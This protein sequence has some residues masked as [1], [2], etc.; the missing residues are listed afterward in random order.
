M[1]IPEVHDFDAHSAAREFLKLGF[2]AVDD[3]GASLYECAEAEL[4]DELGVAVDEMD[5]VTD[6]IETDLGPVFVF[7]DEARI[8]LQHVTQIIRS[9]RSLRA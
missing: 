1:N 5:I 9:H 7:R 4:F 8:T 3:I 2:T 6:R